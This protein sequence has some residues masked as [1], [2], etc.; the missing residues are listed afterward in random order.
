MPHDA[1]HLGPRHDAHPRRAA[2]VVDQNPPL[3][4]LARRLR[5]PAPPPLPAAPVSEPRPPTICRL[6]HWR[7]H[8]NVRLPPPPPPHPLRPPRPSRHDHTP[9][10]ALAPSFPTILVVAASLASPAAVTAAGAAATSGTPPS[11]ARAASAS[12][13][14]S[15]PRLPP[16]F[17]RRLRRYCLCIS[18]MSDDG[19]A[20]V[21]STALHCNFIDDAPIFLDRSADI[22]E[23]ASASLAGLFDSARE[24]WMEAA[25]AC[26]LGERDWEDSDGAED[27]DTPPTD[28]QRRADADADNG[29]WPCQAPRRASVRPQRRPPNLSKYTNNVAAAAVPQRRA[30]KLGADPLTIEELR[31]DFAVEL[32]VALG[33]AAQMVG[34]SESPTVAPRCV[35]GARVLVFVELFDPVC[36]WSASVAGALL[37]FCSCGGILGSG[38]HTFT[39][40]N[41]EHVNLQV[42]RDNSSTCRHARALQLAYDDL[43]FEFEVDSIE[44]L[45][46][47]FPALA[48]TEEDKKAEEDEDTAVHLAFQSGKKKDVPIFAILYESIWSPAIVRRRANKHKLATC[49]LLSCSS[50]PW[51]CIHAQAVNEYNRLEAAAASALA[52]E[53]NEAL[54]FGP[55]GDLNDDGEEQPT[56]PALPTV[57][58]PAAPLPSRLRRA[59]NMFPCTNEVSQCD[60]NA[61]VID[62]CRTAGEAKILD[63]TH[64]ESKCLYCD[65]IRGVDI[66][67]APEEVVLYCMRGRLIIYIGSWLCGSCERVVEYDG[68]ANGLF[69]AT[70]GGVYARTFLDAVLELCVIARSTMAAASELLTSLLRNTAAFAENEPGQARQLLSDACGEFSSTLDIPETAFRCHHCDAEERTGGRF[71]CVICDGQVLSVL[72][73]HVVEM[74]RPGMNAPRV[75]FSLVFACAIRSAKVR[76]LVRNRVRAS[77]ED[78]TA[79]TTAEATAWRV[80]QAAR[81]EARPTGGGEVIPAR[82]SAKKVTALQWSSAT[83]FTTFWEVITSVERQPAAVVAPDAAAVAPAAEPG[84]PAV[85]GGVADDLA[86]SGSDG[87]EANGVAVRRPTQTGRPWI[88]WRQAARPT[89]TLP[90]CLAVPWAWRAR[91]GS[92]RWTSTLAPPTGGRRSAPSPTGPRMKLRLKLVPP[93]MRMTTSRWTPMTC[94]ARRTRGG[95]HSPT[96]QTRRHRAQTH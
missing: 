75:D 78:D 29:D 86:T 28:E 38:R 14:S 41:I 88:W 22:Y 23:P 83:L 66:Q 34:V 25:A 45:L 33:L 19:N 24:A 39:R 57:D 1:R 51:S 80:F 74:L 62:A 32:R 76:R 6:P 55:A 5:L 40:E 89:A 50:H 52:A 7:T 77:I 61:A 79:L 30:P 56:D 53:L 2:T 68:S 64:A 16:A 96:L 91:Q 71:R 84:A 58:A 37:T 21:R 46:D 4:A 93:P 49:F 60:R 3:S 48:G 36:V 20:P 44:D 69:I 8:T 63:Y 31:V 95:R 82:T 15:A 18:I 35:S 54:Q 72:Q 81:S 17:P 27:G 12:A 59:R 11:A 92:C 13:P 9:T 26:E 73:E 10:G 65:T 70:R 87:S 47:L 42:A 94:R 43:A 85:V 90:T 67:V